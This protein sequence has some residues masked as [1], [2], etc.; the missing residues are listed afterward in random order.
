[1]EKLSLIE[2][3]LNLRSFYHKI[4]AG[5][6]ANANTPGYK[7]KDIDF[8]SEMRR[9]IK[10]STQIRILED[11]E[12]SGQI[13]ARDGNTVDLEKEVVKLTEN[14]LAYSAL[15]RVITKKFSMIRY[16]INEGRR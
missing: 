7:R 5:N 14:F 1:M 12:T 3:A 13:E 4:L 6:V 8:E 15:I 11:H 2:K 9:E 10:N 16:I